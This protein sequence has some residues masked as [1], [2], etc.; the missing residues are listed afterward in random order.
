[1]RNCN[2]ATNHWPF[3]PCYSS[4]ILLYYRGQVFPPFQY[5]EALTNYQC[6]LVWYWAIFP[7]ITRPMNWYVC[8]INFWGIAVLLHFPPSVL[9][10]VCWHFRVN[11]TLGP[12]EDRYLRT[13]R[14]TV[15]DIYCICCQ[16]I[17][18]WR[19]VSR[20]DIFF[21]HLM[22]IV[23]YFM[24]YMQRL[25]KMSYYCRAPWKALLL[26]ALLGLCCYDLVNLIY[27]SRLIGLLHNDTLI[28]PSR[29]PFS[30]L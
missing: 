22:M 3:W 30:T 9:W 2:T 6:S 23:S 17:L 29:L 8:W 1:M 18:G 20:S 4:S 28:S 13:G 16:E 5:I 25:Q 11:V 21:K 15:N 24:H 12:N 26:Y 10:F 27:F 7:K 14:H 19:Y